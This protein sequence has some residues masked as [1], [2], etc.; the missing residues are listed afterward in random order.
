MQRLHERHPEDAE[1]AIL[2]MVMR[3][4]DLL[5]AAGT[6]LAA[7]A[8]PRIGRAEGLRPS[9]LS[10]CDRRQYPDLFAL[11]QVEVDIRSADEAVRVASR[12][13]I[14]PRKFGVSDRHYDEL[15]PSPCG[16]AM[17]R[18]SGS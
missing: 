13:A 1:A 17:G 11:D 14:T 7:L 6:S 4:R 8:A 16:G 3:R 5:K 2:Q 9:L 10:Q 12:P 15:P 18:K